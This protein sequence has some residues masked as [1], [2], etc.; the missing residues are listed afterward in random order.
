MSINALCDL[1]LVSKF[2]VIMETSIFVTDILL[3]FSLRLDLRMLARLTLRFGLLIVLHK[4]K[5]RSLRA[6]LRHDVL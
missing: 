5:N 1:V 6:N 2:A 4:L 3:S